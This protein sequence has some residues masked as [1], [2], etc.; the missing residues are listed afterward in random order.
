MSSSL[1]CD[2][3]SGSKGYEWICGLFFGT[4]MGLFSVRYT[5]WLPVYRALQGSTTPA[6]RRARIEAATGRIKENSVSIDLQY[7]NKC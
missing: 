5:P 4:S 1:A 7:L 6:P 3:S 2:F